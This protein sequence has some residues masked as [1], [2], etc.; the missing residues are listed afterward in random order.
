MSTHIEQLEEQLK[1]AESLAKH[2]ADIL[3]K[4][5][6]IKWRHGIDTAARNFHHYEG[7]RR[8]FEDKLFKAKLKE[9]LREKT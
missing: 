6:E 3:R 4:I 8:F 5:Q 2:W 9:A 7:R 1:K